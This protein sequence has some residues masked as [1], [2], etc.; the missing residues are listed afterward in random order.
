MSTLFLYKQWGN[1]SFGGTVIPLLTGA[2]S[3]PRHLSHAC[4]SM[5]HA[6]LSQ[7]GDAW[8]V[9]CTT[10]VGNVTQSHRVSDHQGLH[11]HGVQHFQVPFG[12]SVKLR[13]A[14]NIRHTRG[15]RHG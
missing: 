3:A 5:P 10:D 12:L 7:D 8:K 6:S 1:I 14:S 11:T 15:H 13:V 9:L 4:A 2:A